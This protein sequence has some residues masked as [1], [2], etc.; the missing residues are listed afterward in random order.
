MTSWSKNHQG[1]A[2]CCCVF[3]KSWPCRTWVR[4]RWNRN[5]SWPEPSPP[6]WRTSC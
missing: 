1:R 6:R 2:T 4:V 3:P 5:V